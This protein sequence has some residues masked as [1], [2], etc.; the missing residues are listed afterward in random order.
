M[1]SELTRTAAVRHGARTRRV[2]IAIG[3]RSLAAVASGQRGWPKRQVHPWRAE[4]APMGDDGSWDALAEAFAELRASLGCRRIVARVALLPPLAHTKV[5]R[6]PRVRRSDLGLL[7]RRNARRY[8]AIGSEPVLVGGRRIAGVAGQDS[9]AVAGCA[10]ERVVHAIGAAADSAGITVEEITTGS[11]AFASWPHLRRVLG[12]RRSA[13][14]VHSAEWSEVIHTSD[15]VPFAFQPML[16]TGS[17]DEDAET[18]NRE[19]RSADA[20]ALPERTLVFCGNNPETEALIAALATRGI[21][22]P[23]PLAF[24]EGSTL[25]PA[26]AAAWAVLRAGDG[27]PQLLTPELD[28]KRKVRERRRTAIPAVA[29]AAILAAAAGTHLWGVRQEIEAVERSRQALAPALADALEARQATASVR[30]WLQSI[31]ELETKNR[32]EWTETLAGVA[33]LLPDSAHLTSFVG[34]SEQVRLSGIAR[35]AHGVVPELQRSPLFREASFSAPLQRD[36]RT[37]QERFDVAIPRTNT[38]TV[39]SKPSNR[40]GS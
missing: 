34:D 17:T 7:L 1:H 37:N 33:R 35:Q 28:R 24:S 11:A 29:A 18:V 30:G 10:A 4:I 38:G 23:F 25:C 13:A 31:V 26:S 27:L 12:R 14:V 39:G 21:P 22:H 15:G 20:E 6:L 36:E 2:G 19:I 32:P 8:F 40:G 3:E 9:V 16:R 5:V